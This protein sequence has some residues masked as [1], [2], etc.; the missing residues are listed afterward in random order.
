MLSKWHINS[1]K[2]VLANS[3]LGFCLS[4]STSSRKSLKIR[5]HWPM[6]LLDC[7]QS[8][9][10]F[11]VDNSSALSFHSPSVLGK[12][13]QKPQLFSLSWAHTRCFWVLLL[14]SWWQITSG[15]VEDTAS[16]SPISS[17][18]AESIGT[19]MNVIG[20]HLWLGSSLL[21][22]SYR[23]C[24]KAWEWRSL[25]RASWI[26]TPGTMCLLLSFP[27]CFVIYQ[28]PLELMIRV[29]V[30]CIWSM[31]WMQKSWTVLQVAMEA[32]LTK[33]ISLERRDFKVV[34]YQKLQV[35]LQRVFKRFLLEHENWKRKKRKTLIYYS[36]FI[37]S[38]NCTK[39]LGYFII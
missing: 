8:I 31:V 37:L 22:L 35:P 26:C 27:G 29:L 6:M 34:V 7:S 20:E 23:E 9:S 38:V 1:F 24:F 21:L 30:S 15:F 17:N 3:S 28:S 32:T 36:K 14:E 25:T 18:R 16:I 5:F 12:F 10:T 2:T 19:T 4:S 39:I 11:N 33:L 13:K